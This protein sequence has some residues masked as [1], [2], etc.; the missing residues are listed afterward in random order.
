MKERIKE[1]FKRMNECQRSE[2][3]WL[4]RIYRSRGPR[5]VTRFEKEMKGKYVVQPR[6]NSTVETVLSLVSHIVTKM[7]NLKGPARFLRKIL[8]C[9]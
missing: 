5:Y 6:Y 3:R 2:A 7:K 1:R 9:T 4:R 8:Y